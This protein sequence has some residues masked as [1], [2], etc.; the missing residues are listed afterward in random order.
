MSL[1]IRRKEDVNTPY[2]VLLSATCEK[3]V[4][5]EY[6]KGTRYPSGCHH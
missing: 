5:K 1:S 6:E 2:W 4:G 3:Q